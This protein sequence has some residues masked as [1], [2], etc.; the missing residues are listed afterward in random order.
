[1]PPRVPPMHFYPFVNRRYIARDKSSSAIA[2][3][4]TRLP[5]LL[6]VSGALSGRDRYVKG[7]LR[8]CL[9]RI[10]RIVVVRLGRLNNTY[11]A[12]NGIRRA[13]HDGPAA[14]NRPVRL[15]FFKTMMERLPT[16][17]LLVVSVVAALVSKKS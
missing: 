2:Y 4:F 3:H 16:E 14:G 10:S 8:C 13:H 11:L 1:M 5:I 9:V 7:G 6:L 17:M 15:A 12:D